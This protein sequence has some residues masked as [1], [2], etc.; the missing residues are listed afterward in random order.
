MW[1]FWK[2]RSRPS[3]DADER[4]ERRLVVTSQRYQ[5]FFRIAGDILDQ[6]AVERE[7]S[8][9]VS[10]SRHAVHIADFISVDAMKT[11]VESGE[12]RD[13]ESWS[14]HLERLGNASMEDLE[15]D[16]WPEANVI[17]DAFD[18]P[19]DAAAQ[20]YALNDSF[21]GFVRLLVSWIEQQDD[22]RKLYGLSKQQGE[23]QTE[24]QIRLASVLSEEVPGLPSEDLLSA[25]IFMMEALE[26]DSD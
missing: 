9:E 16:D 14:H 20:V 24:F 11:V 2:S 13:M 4:L 17:F 6:V 22:Y 21:A 15:F 12:L 25:T 3:D 5:Q 1:K 10:R 19:H 7:G 18:D 8:D 26:R 23:D